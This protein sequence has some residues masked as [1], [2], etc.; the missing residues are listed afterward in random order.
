[1]TKEGSSYH[2]SGQFIYANFSPMLWDCCQTKF[3]LPR[4]YLFAQT[5]FFA[6]SLS[7]LLH[8]PC[9]ACL[10]LHS[11]RQIQLFVSTPHTNGHIK[12]PRESS[13]WSSILGSHIRLFF[14]LHV[15][16]AIKLF[17]LTLWGSTSTLSREPEA[18]SDWGRCPVCSHIRF[19][20]LLATNAIV[21]SHVIMRKHINAKHRDRGVLWSR[22][23]PADDCCL[24]PLRP[25]TCTP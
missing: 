1:M 3:A 20:F 23:R 12:S 9:F 10:F 24:T 2:C 7:E 19:L 17:T 22:Q 25:D 15:I 13:S 11:I 14:L 18:S 5:I 21:H 6:Q 16:T 8:P 4:N